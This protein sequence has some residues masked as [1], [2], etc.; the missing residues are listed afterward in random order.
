MGTVSIW[1][2]LIVLMCGIAPMFPIGTILKKAGFSPLWAILWIVPLINVIGFLI[3]AYSRWP[4]S[5]VPASD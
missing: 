4:A 2:W 5:R 3:F 1:H